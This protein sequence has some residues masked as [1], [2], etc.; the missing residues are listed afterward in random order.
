MFCF[1]FFFAL[2]YGSGPRGAEEE[3]PLRVAVGVAVV[4]GV[5]GGHRDLAVDQV[6]D[7]SMSNRPSSCFTH[8][9]RRRSLSR[10]L[11]LQLRRLGAENR[12]TTW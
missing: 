1:V 7:A 3:L 11:Q 6:L 9:F 12:I 5:G 2:F 8:E 10:L 4:R